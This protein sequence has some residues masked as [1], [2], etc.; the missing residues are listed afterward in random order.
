[1]PWAAGSYTKGNDGTGGWTGDA[2]NGIGIEA[3]RHDTQDNDFTTGINSTLTKDGSNVPSA[4][5]PMGGFRHTG[6]G[7]ATARDSYAT[8][9]Q[10]QDGTAIWGGTSGGTANAQTLTLSPA[11]TAYAAGQRFGFFAVATNTGALTININGVGAKAVQWRNLAL[12]GNEIE[13]NSAVEIVYDGTAFQSVQLAG[14]ATARAQAPTLGQVQDSTALWGGTSG[15]SA[16]AQTLTL[17]PA[18]TAYVAGQRFRFVAGF[19]NTAAATLNVNG[20]GAVSV[21]LSTTGGALTSNYIEAGS[22]YE[23][24]HNG[25]NFRLLGDPALIKRGDYENLGTSTGTANALVLTSSGPRLTSTSTIRVFEF[26]PNLTNTAAVTVA[27]DGLPAI[28]LYNPDTSA[29]AAGQLVGGR[30]YQLMLTNGNAIVINPSGEWVNFSPVISQTATFTY[31][32]NYSYYKRVGSDLVVWRFGVTILTGA[33][34]AG[35]QLVMTPPVAPLIQASYFAD[36]AATIFDTSANFIYTCVGNF[37]G[38]TALRFYTGSGTVANHFGATP[39]LGVAVG[40]II[41]GVITYRV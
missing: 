26:I 37:V 11:I 21:V 41:S 10:A 27:I 23:V 39:F 38:S 2:G 33:G 15:G 17:T 22:I 3:G 36:G 30:N 34:T 29:L 7:L 19:T 32:N 6:V 40:D 16:N 5:L 4:N 24:L 18:I 25:T 1:M 8:L 12:T 35:Q 13:I 9:G 14:N 31:T 28:N 20:V